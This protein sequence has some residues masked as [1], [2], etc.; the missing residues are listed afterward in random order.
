MQMSITQM[1]QTY[2]GHLCLHT[3]MNK[4]TAPCSEDCDVEEAVLF[5]LGFARKSVVGNYEIVCFL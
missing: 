3:E 5:N 2:E 1:F 4:V